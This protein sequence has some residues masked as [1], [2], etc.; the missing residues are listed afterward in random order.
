MVE[1]DPMRILQGTLASNAKLGIGIEEDINI[2]KPLFDLKGFS[3]D[4]VRESRQV[5]NSFSAHNVNLRCCMYI[6]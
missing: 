3:A 4:Q 1:T 5:F 6:R 2:Q